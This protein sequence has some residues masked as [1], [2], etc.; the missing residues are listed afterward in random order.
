MRRVDQRLGVGLFE[1]GQADVHFDVQAET[2]GDLAD[3]YLGGDGGVGRDAALA[4]AGDEFRPASTQLRR[5]PE[6]DDAVE[7]TRSA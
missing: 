4:L 7:I 6:I 2:A 1:T 5:L 3:A